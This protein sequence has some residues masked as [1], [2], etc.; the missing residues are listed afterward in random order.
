MAINI[1]QD[2]YDFMIEFFI[3]KESDK[4]GH[5]NFIEKNLMESM[6]AKVGTAHQM[7]ENPELF[8]QMNKM[9]LKEH[10]GVI[11]QEMADKDQ[12]LASKEAPKVPPSYFKRIKIHNMNLYMTL[13]SDYFY[14]LAVQI[15]L[16]EL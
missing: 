6:K 12:V 2:F 9:T 13:K 15:E 4:T 8:Y 7:L 11:T 5:G 10:R 3:S 14:G 1:T 16:P